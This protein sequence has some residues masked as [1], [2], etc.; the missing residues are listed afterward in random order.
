MDSIHITIPFSIKE[1]RRMVRPK[2]IRSY[3]AKQSRLKIFDLQVIIEIFKESFG[4]IGTS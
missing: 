3:L 1:S 4:P 2:D